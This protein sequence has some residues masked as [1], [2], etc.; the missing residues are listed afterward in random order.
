MATLPVLQR[1]KL[2]K[3]DP[4][5]LCSGG[6]T[7]ISLYIERDAAIASRGGIKALQAYLQRKHRESRGKHDERG[8]RDDDARQNGARLIAHQFAV[9]RHD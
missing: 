7:S 6:W 1:G 4:R 3:P 5:P 9:A 2:R 8:N